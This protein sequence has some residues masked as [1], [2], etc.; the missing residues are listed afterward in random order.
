[1]KTITGTFLKPDGTAVA[2]G[3]LVLRLPYAATVIATAQVAP[4]LLS[5]TLD[6]SGTLG[7]GVQIYAN[8]ELT[9]SGTYYNMSVRDVNDVSVSR[10]A[11][12]QL[13]GSSPINLNL[14]VPTSNGVT[15]PS[16]LLLPETATQT[17]SGPLALTDITSSGTGTFANINGTR[18]A[19][20]FASIQLAIDAVSAAGGG[21]VFVPKG[22]Y[23][24]AATINLASNVQ[25]EGTGQKSKIVVTGSATAFTAAGASNWCVKNI[26]ID[27]TGTS[28]LYAFDVDASSADYVI[29]GITITGVTSAVLINGSTRLKGTNPTVRNSTFNGA[30]AV[31]L[32]QVV[33]GAVTDNT[34]YA[35]RTGIIVA[36]SSGNSD[37]HVLVAG[38]RFL[39]K[40]SATTNGFDS[41]LVENSNYVTISKNTIKAAPEHC[42]YVSDSTAGSSNIAIIGNQCAGWGSG[43]AIQVRGN[44]LNN[45]VTYNTNVTIEGNIVNGTKI[46]N[47]IGITA[48][49]IKGLSMS[50]NSCYNA[51]LAN[52]YLDNIIGA[53]IGINVSDGSAAAGFYHRD[54][55]AGSKNVSYV[56]C[57]ANNGNSGGSGLAGFQVTLTGGFA[58]S[59]IRFLG[60]QAS[61]FQ[62][63]ATQTTGFAISTPSGG[64]TLDDIEYAHCSGTGNTVLLYNTNVRATTAGVTA[65]GLVEFSAG[66][67]TVRPTEDTPAVSTSSFGNASTVAGTYGML[68]NMGSADATTLGLNVQFAGNPI[69]RVL[70]TRA[71]FSG[72]G[73][74][75]FAGPV[76]PSAAGGTTLGIALL[77]W[78]NLFIGNAATNNIKLTGT[79]TAARTATLPDKSITVAGTASETFTSPTVNTSVLQ[80]SGLKHQRVTTGAIGATSSVDVTLTWTSAFADA[81]YT[82]VVSVVESTG[83]LTA[84]I[85][86]FSASA[87]VVTVKNTSAGSLTGTLLA[88]AMHD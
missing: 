78:S 71:I 45:G 25:L 58:S 15:Y 86:S 21:T 81:N 59:N 44:A 41:V 69:F 22:T 76:A 40:I 16:A 9:P 73:N 23:T 17:M 29:D 13:S 72:A 54:L 52:Y 1:M 39:T 2:N 46:A 49:G 14:A 28:S 66:A 27:T 48:Q 63:V 74:H 4:T 42:I 53:T 20:R 64:S 60:C 47:T 68:V 32:D 82:P 3:R 57:Q 26:Q 34:F 11:R 5:F 65:K 18:Y 6:A 10:E 19:D 87:V 77:P 67:F 55:L 8:D 35:Y 33:G 24:S 36:D 70:G 75:T 12:V 7:A 31:W 84:T 88:Q 85:K 50:G 37:R 38:N 51:G 83:I 56:G 80:G 62:T 61:D 43:S 30:G 79:A